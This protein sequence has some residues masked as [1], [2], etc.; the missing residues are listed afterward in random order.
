M[1]Q[2]YPNS[3][4]NVKNREYTIFALALDIATN[5]GKLSV[6]KGGKR[7]RILDINETFIKLLDMLLAKHTDKVGRKV[8]GRPRHDHVGN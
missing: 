7:T 3:Y 4:E 6:L 2:K 1:K 8:I 5:I